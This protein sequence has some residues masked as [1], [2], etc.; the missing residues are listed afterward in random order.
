MKGI[1]VEII[2]H[3]RAEVEERRRSVP[4]E[5]LRRRA[6][7][8]PPCRDF[9][10]ALRRTNGLKLLA[11]IKAA[12]PSAGTLRDEFDPA[13][14]ASAFYQSGASAISVLT[15]FKYFKGTDSHL[16]AARQATPLPVLRKDFTI[17]EYQLV[18][19]RAIGADA[20]LLMAQVLAPDDYKRLYDLARE[21][22]LYVLAE[23]HTPE[24][25][26]FLVSLGA[27]T[28]GIN[29]RDF[30]TM[31]VDLN[32]TVERRAIVP[33]DRVLV[34]QSGVFTR[35]DVLKLET[36]RPDAIQVGSSIMRHGDAA[37]QIALLMG[38][39]T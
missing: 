21:L 1:L 29:N 14:Y 19:S 20:V 8:A 23:G 30:E 32:T 12:S 5:T 39:R 35:D 24:Q 10:T 2:E 18:E 31:T 33:L 22:G 38:P 9:T 17:D 27:E 16:V 4:L 25:L 13:E 34:S 6:A 28:I 15:D 7:E 11:E 36:V 37:E 26:E 3:K